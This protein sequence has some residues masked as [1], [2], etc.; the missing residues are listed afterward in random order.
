MRMWPNDFF[1]DYADTLRAHPDLDL[2]NFVALWLAAQ[3]LAESAV[4]LGFEPEDIPDILLDI[5]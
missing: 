2:G 5:E 3:A 1:I 4:A